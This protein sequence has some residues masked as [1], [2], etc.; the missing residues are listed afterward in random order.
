LLFRQVDHFRH[1]VDAD[2]APGVK[3]RE[4][5]GPEAATTPDFQNI[6]VLPAQPQPP[7]AG[8]FD[9][10]VQEP[11]YWAVDSMKFGIDESHGTSL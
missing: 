7:E 6:L 8:K 1:E 10:A 4:E 5:H 3:R 11:S 9:I 2:V